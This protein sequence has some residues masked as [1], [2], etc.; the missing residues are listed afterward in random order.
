MSYLEKVFE[1]G[2][3]LEYK[4][5]RLRIWRDGELKASDWAMTIDA[6]TDKNA[7]AEYRQALRDLTQNVNTLK[8][9]D[10]PIKPQ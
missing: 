7:W 3:S 4:L 10:L 5:E 6:P 1:E 9:K 8:A 2:I